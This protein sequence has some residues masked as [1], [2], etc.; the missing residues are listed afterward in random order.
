[1]PRRRGGGGVIWRPYRRIL[2][3]YTIQRE[4]WAAREG[5]LLS[6]SN[7]LV[8]FLIALYY[9]QSPSPPQFFPPDYQRYPPEGPCAGPPAV[10]KYNHPAWCVVI[11]KKTLR[12]TSPLRFSHRTQKST[13]IFTDQP[14]TRC[15]L[16]PMRAQPE[17]SFRFQWFS[18]RT[19]RVRSAKMMSFGI[20]L[21]SLDIK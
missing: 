21:S 14:R 8:I 10:G 5:G 16:P 12:S 2:E 9:F 6:Y 1:M 7:F 17:P 3:R 18:C 19:M 11:H 15:S 20:S 4:R 13:R